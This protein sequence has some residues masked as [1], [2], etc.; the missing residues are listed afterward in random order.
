[1]DYFPESLHRFYI[2]HAD[3]FTRFIYKTLKLILDQK[4]IDKVFIF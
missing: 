2:L 4:I 1:M 3:F